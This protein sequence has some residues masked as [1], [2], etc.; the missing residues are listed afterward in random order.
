LQCK[1]GIAL[2]YRLENDLSL[3]NRIGNMI[4]WLGTFGKTKSGGVTRLLFSQTWQ[5]AQFALKD[6]MG[7]LGFQTY[8]DS[9]GNLFGRMTGS[10]DKNHIILTGSHID[11]VVNGGKYDGAYGIIA[12]LLAVSGL[13][14]RFGYPKKTIEVVS[15]AE[16]E[17][18]R[19]PLTF[20]GSRNISGFYHLEHVKNLQDDHGVTFFAAMRAAGFAPEKYKPA[21]R[22][23]IERFIELHIEQGMTLEK[24]HNSIGVVTHIVGQRRYTV[25]IKGESNHAG[26]TPMEGRKDAVSTASYLISYLTKRAKEIDKQLVATVG[27]LHVTPNVANVIAGEVE[28]SLDIRHHEEQILDFY[29]QELFSMFENVAI[30]LAMDISVS[31][32]MDVKPVRMDD[33]LNNWIREVALK[34]KICFQDIVSGAGHDAQVFA[35]ICP[36]TLLFVPSH[37]GISH[38]P[39]EFTS[40]EDLATGIHL[41]E[42]ILYKLAYD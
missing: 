32:W 5:E 10:I 42:T 23:D 25:R 22:T 16:E 15:L 35:S 20:W 19:F 1:G 28:F 6:K 11:T 9:A 33:E 12:S 30:S 31:Q 36:T 24:N 17:G 7:E 14:E 41:L 37:K 34:Q 27:K 2:A 26:T 21:A 8:F 40:L 39:Q 18:S 3:K 13:V 29:C 38:S 4:E